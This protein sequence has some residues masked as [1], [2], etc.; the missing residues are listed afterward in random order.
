M[1]S[2]EGIKSADREPLNPQQ[3]FEAATMF[4]IT[5]YPVLHI[6]DTEC[7]W[8]EV[9]VMIHDPK[10]EEEDDVDDVHG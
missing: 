7:H 5:H 2:N 8:C 4:V 10:D 9:C 1:N 6:G 3:L